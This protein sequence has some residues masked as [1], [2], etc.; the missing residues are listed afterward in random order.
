MSHCILTND[1][2]IYLTE[3]PH[4]IFYKFQKPSLHLGGGVDEVGYWKDVEFIARAT[5]GR[6]EKVP[7]DDESAH[8]NVISKARYIMPRDITMLLVWPRGV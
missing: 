8:K 6:L 1:C 3:N 5:R 4:I 2:Q 7:V